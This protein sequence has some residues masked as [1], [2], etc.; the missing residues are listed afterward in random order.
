MEVQPAGAGAAGSLS[1]VE[2]VGEAEDGWADLPDEEAD[3]ASAL[4]QVP[5]PGAPTDTS[6]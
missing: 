2:K 3:V 1:S 6:N 5:P 4:P